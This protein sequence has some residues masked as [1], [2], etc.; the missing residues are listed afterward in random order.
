MG[1]IVK[2]PYTITKNGY[3]VNIGKMKIP[4][5]ETLM[6]IAIFVLA[7][8]CLNFGAWATAVS[9]STAQNAVYNG[10]SLSSG[11]ID[12]NTM[13]INCSS[14]AQT[15]YKQPYHPLNLSHT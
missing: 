13:I 1:F 11:G 8:F 9:I 7:A 4:V 12:N 10:C 6:V 2:E 15:D 14:T 5:Q 3:V